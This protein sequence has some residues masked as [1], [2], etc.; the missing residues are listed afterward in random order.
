MTTTSNNNV[1]P[2]EGKKCSQVSQWLA[3]EH[4][5][6]QAN[7]RPLREANP[8]KLVSRNRTGG[9]A[10]FYAT[11][12][13]W[14]GVGKHS[15]RYLNLMSMNISIVKDIKKNVAQNRLKEALEQ[16]KN[17]FSKHSASDLEADVIVLQG[18]LSSYQRQINRGEEIEESKLNRIRYS[19]LSLTEELERIIGS[20][21]EETTESETQSEVNQQSTEA[22]APPN[23]PTFSIS[24]G[25]LKGEATFNQANVI[26]QQFH[27]KSTKGKSEHPKQ[28]GYDKKST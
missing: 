6:L 10:G 24:I 20:K 22:V 16:L 18:N 9:K 19:I 13:M 15:W 1:S 12:D 8:I 7:L 14:G 25:A 27:E 4:F 17:S 5:L 28:G 26:N 21:E 2:Y 11:G 3:G 23:I